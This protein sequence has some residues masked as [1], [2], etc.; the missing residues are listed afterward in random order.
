[1]KPSS[2]APPF[3]RP[4]YLINGTD[5]Q[6]VTINGDQYLPFTHSLN[7]MVEQA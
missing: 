1:M 4:D 5:Y 6:R 7:A 2:Y 3:Q